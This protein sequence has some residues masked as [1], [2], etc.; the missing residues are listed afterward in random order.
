[1]TAWQAWLRLPLWAHLY[2]RP[3]RARLE[4]MA[5]GTTVATSLSAALAGLGFPAPPPDSPVI[6]ADEAMICRAWAAEGEG[7]PLAALPDGLLP[8][9]LDGRLRVRVTEETLAA[10]T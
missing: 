2:T 3:A 8:P 10:A 5:Y 6:P 9:V 1:M 4:G 7:A